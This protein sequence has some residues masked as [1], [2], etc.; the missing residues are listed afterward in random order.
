MNETLYCVVHGTGNEWEGLCLDLDIAVHGKS[1]NEVKALLD[2]AVRTFI[3][4]A[5]NEDEPTRKAL[6]SRRAPLHT[7]AYWA[8]RIAIAALRG[9]SR[10][11]DLP[12]GYPVTC[13]T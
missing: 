7:R 9:R 3:Q 13:H 1:F 2:E 5:M 4:D 10:N 11:R 12:V 8:A 6:L